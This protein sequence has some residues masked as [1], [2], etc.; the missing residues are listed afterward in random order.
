MI[1]FE[2]LFSV[3]LHVVL[4]SY[5]SRVRDLISSSNKVQSYASRY[6]NDFHLFLV[7]ET[8]VNFLSVSK[9]QLIITLKKM[10]LKNIIFSPH[11]K[12]S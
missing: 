3:S 5:S 8:F 9:D 11:S 12:R 10:I 2:N 1:S 4:V 6:A 7:E